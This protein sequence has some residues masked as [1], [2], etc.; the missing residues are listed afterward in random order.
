MSGTAS[1]NALL[2][3]VRDGATAV[4]FILVTFIYVA[5]APGRMAA[6]TGCLFALVGLCLA[7]TLHELGHALAALMCRHRVLVFAVR[8]VAWNLPNRSVALMAKGYEPGTGG[9]V[10]H[11]PRD[12][13]ALTVGRS[14]IITAAGPLANI[15][16]AI[17]AFAI[18]GRYPSPPFYQG[19]QI[20]AAGTAFGAQ[21]LWLAI[22]NLLPLSQNRPTD[23]A[24]LLG[25]LRRPADWHTMKML[26]A[27]GALMRYNVRLRDRPDWLIAELRVMERSVEGLEQTLRC[28]EIGMALDAESVDVALTRR[29]LDAFHGDYGDNEWLASCDAYFIAVWERDAKR[30]AARAWRGEPWEHDHAMAEAATAAIMAAAGDSVAVAAHLRSM[31]AQL[32]K[33][34]PFADPTFRDITR[35]VEGVLADTRRQPA[36]AMLP[37]SL[38]V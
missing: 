20:D 3:R 4:V 31:N 5:A 34:S 1:W 24:K 30:A 23:G 22:V 38:T 8:P 35:R 15:A 17:A 11:V 37:K 27:L 18:A 9:L 36:A 10:V 21:S 14:A 26:G 32:A 16:A 6:G 28:M 29:L 2:I 19:F 13:G 25:L 12:A 7:I 33:R